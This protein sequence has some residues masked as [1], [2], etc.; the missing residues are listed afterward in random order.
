MYKAQTVPKGGLKSLGFGE[1]RVDRENSLWVFNP[2]RGWVYCS[3]SRATRF[4]RLH[5]LAKRLGLKSFTF[6]SKRFEVWS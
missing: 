6:E 2:Q 3:E 4:A 1:Y 5:T